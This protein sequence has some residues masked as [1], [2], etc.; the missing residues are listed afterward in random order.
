MEHKHTN[1]FRQA[2]GFTLLKIIYLNIDLSIFLH[3]AEKKTVISITFIQK[4]IMKY[5]L[6]AVLC[7]SMLVSCKQKILSGK[8]LENKLIETMS[9]HLHQTLKPGTEFT[10]K[11][12]I[13][14]PEKEKKLYICQFHV[15]VRAP[16]SKDTT[17]VMR[18][19]ISND[20]KNV[21]RTQ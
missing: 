7:V 2:T 3:D 10:I 12:I 15:E 13:Y 9:D 4:S 1:L 16:G 21:S 14:Y 20:F 18:A 19:L 5:L 11:D 8:E 6:T 17:G